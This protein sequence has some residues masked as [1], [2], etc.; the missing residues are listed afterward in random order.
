[1]ARGLLFES[2]ANESISKAL[3]VLGKERAQI[4]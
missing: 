3:K 1:M 4:P 2:F